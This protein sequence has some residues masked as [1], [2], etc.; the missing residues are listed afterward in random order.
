MIGFID[1]VNVQTLKKLENKTIGVLKVLD[2]GEIWQHKS[3]Q[4]KGKHFQEWGIHQETDFPF[5]SYDFN[6]ETVN[7]FIFQSSFIVFNF[8]LIAICYNFN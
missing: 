4:I 8:F 7:W 5:I 6:M 1:R 3:Q 2:F